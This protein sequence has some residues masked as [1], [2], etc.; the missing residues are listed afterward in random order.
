[1]ALELTDK[2]SVGEGLPVEPKSTQNH[3]YPSKNYPLPL[4][5]SSMAILDADSDK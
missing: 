1:V 2:N 3:D 4:T 5:S